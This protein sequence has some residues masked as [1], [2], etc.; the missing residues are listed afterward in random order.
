MNFVLKMMNLDAQL[1]RIATLGM[2]ASTL[3][4]DE[5]EDK[6]YT[7]RSIC[8]HNKS[9]NLIYLPAVDRSYLPHSICKHNKSHNLHLF[10]GLNYA[11]SPE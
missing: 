11:C 3:D 1:E 8:I 10:L 6:K 9:H 7:L 5:S 4:G 2:G